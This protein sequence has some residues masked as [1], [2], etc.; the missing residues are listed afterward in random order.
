ML[1]LGL[2]LLAM[3][4][5]G[6]DPVAVPAAP[7]DDPA[8]AIKLWLGSSREFRQG[9]R[10]RVQVETQHDGY[11]VVFNYDTDGRL[12]VLFPVNPLDDQ[13]VQAGRR[14]EIEG[15]GDRESFLVGGEGEGLVFAA[16]AADPFDFR[17]YQSASNWDYNRLYISAESA[18]PEADIVDLLQR[19]TS[20]R[21]F[22]YDLVDYRVYGYRETIYSS[23][24]YPRPYGFY[25]DFYCDPWYRP[26]LFGCGYWWPGTRYGFGF[27]VGFYRPYRYGYGYGYGGYGYG[28]WR[29][30]IYRGRPEKD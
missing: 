9:E 14:Y 5:A 3:M 4:P 22:D 18:D 11:L 2:F 12:R 23:A 15:R 25:D 20:E 28:W 30:T 7:T 8:P 6:P 10:A 21:G 26:S 27:G 1:T 24:W 29:N 16:I 19:V 13:L 17:E